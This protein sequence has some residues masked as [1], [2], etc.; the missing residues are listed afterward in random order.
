[1]QVF[2]WGAGAPL[3]LRVTGCGAQTRI[4]GGAALLPR[5]GAL[6]AHSNSVAH[7]QL[8]QP[9][10]SWLDFGWTS[11]ST[12]APSQPGLGSLFCVAQVR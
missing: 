2:A 6:D 11:G 1:M 10:T 5:P 8:A 9:Y 3:V 7:L 4:I 12:A